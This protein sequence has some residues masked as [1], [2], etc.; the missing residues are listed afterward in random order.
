MFDG[1]S[2]KAEQQMRTERERGLK[3][4]LIGAKAKHPQII[5]MRQSF[6]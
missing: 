2:E 4:N 1:L 5:W 6:S 3:S